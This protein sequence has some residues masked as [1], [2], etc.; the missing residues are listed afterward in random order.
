VDAILARGGWWTESV[1]G[2]PDA[3]ECNHIPLL[4]PVAPAVVTLSSVGAF[5]REESPLAD[6]HPVG[7][8]TETG[9]RGPIRSLVTP[10]RCSEHFGGWNDLNS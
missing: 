3:V 2:L 5:H 10:A 8:Q 7:G 4:N 6:I 1:T 9:Q